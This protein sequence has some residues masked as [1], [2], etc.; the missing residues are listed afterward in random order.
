M[1]FSL[2][3]AGIALTGTLVVILVLAFL[4]QRSGSSS[5]E[6]QLPQ[7]PDVTLETS[8]ET[9]TLSDLRGTPVIL[10]FWARWCS[11]CRDEMP[12]MEGFHQKY[13]TSSLVIIGVHRTT[14]ESFEYGVDFARNEVNVTYPLAKDPSGEIFDAFSGHSRITPMTVLIDSD[15]K[16]RETLI[17]PRHKEQF[18]E[19]LQKHFDLNATQ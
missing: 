5:Q 18:E 4:L 13:A 16:I 6:K 3:K 11:F 12:V 19:L 17:G 10:N 14:T 7:A 1:N 9:Y 15:G 8:E 2:G